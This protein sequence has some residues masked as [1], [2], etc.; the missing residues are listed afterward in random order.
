MY[1]WLQPVIYDKLAHWF[2]CGVLGELYGGAVESRM[3]LDIQDL[4][5]WF[6]GIL[7]TCN[8]S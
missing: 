7:R 8:C 4:M 5:E 6:K 1:D 2:W 3:A